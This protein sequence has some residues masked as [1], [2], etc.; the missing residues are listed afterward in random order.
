MA[1][2]FQHIIV[3]VDLTINTEVAIRK[4]IELS[5]TGTT[6][7]LL[8]VQQY[9]GALLSLRAYAHLMKSDHA[10]SADRIHEKLLQWKEAILEEWTH[11]SVCIWIRPEADVQ[12]AIENLSLRLQADMIVIGKN[13]HHSWMPFLNTVIPSRMVRKTGIPV[14]TVKPGAFHHKTRTVV[15]PISSSATRHKME[16][17]VTLCKKFQVTVHLVTF[18]NEDNKPLDFQASALLQMFQ[19]LQTSLHCP[20]EYAVLH[21]SNKARAILKYAYK[22][23][24]DLLLVHPE[25][26]TRVDWMHRH[27][28]DLLPPTSKVQVL[29]IQP[30]S[31]LN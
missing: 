8:H 10:T 18:M 20:V 23:H 4:A 2:S 1:H 19:W 27:I 17:M 16:A 24:A 25:T 9:K 12:R 15:I 14:L 22:I 6:I 21:G 30:A 11:L 3:P 7:H 29:A 5:D 13:S 31:S 28:S 26:E